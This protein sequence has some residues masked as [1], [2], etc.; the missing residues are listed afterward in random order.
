MVQVT[1]QPFKNKGIFGA[2][3]YFSTYIVAEYGFVK[4]YLK[5]KN[6]PSTIIIILNI[7]LN[8]IFSV[9]SFIYMLK[10][11]LLPLTSHF[12]VKCYLAKALPLAG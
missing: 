1:Q 11:D 2:T 7:I 8:I 10:M 5:N 3:V 6:E 12:L 4:Q 9:E